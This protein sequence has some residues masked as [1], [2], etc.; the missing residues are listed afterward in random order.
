MCY[1]FCFLLIHSVKL[2]VFCLFVFSPFFFFNRCV[3]ALRITL[4]GLLSQDVYFLLGLV[5]KKWRG[6]KRREEGKKAIPCAM[7]VPRQIEKIVRNTGCVLFIPL[8]CVFVFLSVRYTDSLFTSQYPH[9]A[10]L[11]F[12]RVKR[13]MN[14]RLEHRKLLI[15]LPIKGHRLS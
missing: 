8:F 6:W 9:S 3:F 14:F 4:W 13:L 11:T 2:F 12:H 1:A 10:A 15:S 5:Y 7:T